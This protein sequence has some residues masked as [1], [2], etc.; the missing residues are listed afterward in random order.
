V[1]GN[2]AADNMAGNINIKSVDG[3]PFK[4]LS[5][6]GLAPDI[7]GGTDEQSPGNDYVLA[8]DLE[9]HLQPDG[10]YPR[11][12]VIETDHPNAPLIEVLVRHK[13]STPSLNRNFKLTNYKANLGRV[14]PGA[15][16]THTIGIHEATTTGELVQVISDGGILDAEVIS[17]SVDPET[18]D[19]SAE[20]RFTVREGTPDGFYYLPLQLYSSSQAV[21][22]IPA[23]VSVGDAPAP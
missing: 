16:V 22:S 15:S 20:V 2:V 7:V 5:V 23:F 9:R 17:Q 1:T 18:D 13:L 19:L 12:L 3:N 8:Y 11:F 4:I 6:H 14:A 21:T 10:R